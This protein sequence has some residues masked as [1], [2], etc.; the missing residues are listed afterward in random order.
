M[1]VY[2]PNLEPTMFILKLLILDYQILKGGRKAPHHWS[3]GG[4]KEYKKKRIHRDF[5]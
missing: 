4:N 1:F 5:Q 2:R 3:D